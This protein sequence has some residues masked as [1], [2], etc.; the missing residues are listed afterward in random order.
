MFGDFSFYLQHK[1]TSEFLRRK[2]YNMYT[3]YKSDVGK[4]QLITQEKSEQ[5]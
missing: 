3:N 1:N 4:M 5:V 2:Y